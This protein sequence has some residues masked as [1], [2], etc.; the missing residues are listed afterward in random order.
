MGNCGFT[1][2]PLSNDKAAQLEMVKIFSFFEDI[3]LEPFLKHVPWDWRSW[4][5]YK[6]SIQKN[7]QLPTNY[8]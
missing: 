3:P 2:A 1:A 8:A 7:I 6:D 5:E 4:S